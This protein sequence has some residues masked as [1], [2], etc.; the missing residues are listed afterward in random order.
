MFSYEGKLIDTFGLEST[1]L[2]PEDVPFFRVKVDGPGSFAFNSLVTDLK[3]M[4]DDG[5][6]DRKEYYGELNVAKTSLDK[7][8]KLETSDR[9]A[10]YW[11]EVETL[12]RQHISKLQFV[13]SLLKDT[14]TDAKFSP[15]SGFYGPATGER[16]P[17]FPTYTGFKNGSTS[18]SRFQSSSKAREIRKNEPKRVDDKIKELFDR[19]FKALGKSAGSNAKFAASIIVYAEDFIKNNSHILE[20]ITSPEGQTIVFS[21][22]LNA[23][24]RSILDLVNSK[25]GG[26]PELP[27][28]FQK[29]YEEARDN[30]ISTVYKKE[31]INREINNSDRVIFTLIDAILSDGNL[32]SRNSKAALN[33]FRLVAVDKVKNEKWVIPSDVLDFEDFKTL[34][35]ADRLNQIK[36]NIDF[37]NQAIAE[38]GKQVGDA[39]F[40]PSAFLAWAMAPSKDPKSSSLSNMQVLLA[41]TA[42]NETGAMG[43]LGAY[44][45][46]LMGGNKDLIVDTHNFQFLSLFNGVLF[47]S[48]YLPNGNLKEKGRSKLKEVA[49]QIDNSF[50]YRSDQSLI[51]FL[52]SDE[53]Q[54]KIKADKTLNK[55]YCSAARECYQIQTISNK[56]AKELK[57]VIEKAIPYLDEKVLTDL[58]FTDAAGNLRKIGISEINQLVYVMVVL[59]ST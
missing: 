31:N 17:D 36:R 43:K 37:V 13:P 29:N 28:K 22:M 5:L 23:E 53:S 30:A 50:K 57:D 14:G 58:G 47:G 12:K 16:I 33:L 21:E 8:Q 27:G 45:N 15:M 56:R 42:Q 7:V 24:L 6:I 54:S 39:P 2:K 32:Q 40:N 48:D 19:D 34:I 4:Y 46:F 3:A 1:Y 51:N 38:H 44:F 49:E 52:V 25:G 20:Y 55:N 59:S 10:S 11:L 18:S 26:I 9:N 41:R 35:P